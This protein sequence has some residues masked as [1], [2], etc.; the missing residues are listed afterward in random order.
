MKFHRLIALCSLLLIFPPIL[1]CSDGRSRALK[2]TVDALFHA[3]TIGETDI[4]FKLKQ[5]MLM[6]LDESQEYFLSTPNLEFT[7]PRSCRSITFVDK[8]W[9]F[10]LEY[11]TNKGTLIATNR[12]FPPNAPH[13]AYIYD[14]EFKN[15]TIEEIPGTLRIERL[16]DD[17]WLQTTKGRLGICFGV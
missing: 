8:D 14:A 2:P 15:G 11:D 1:A 5:R 10:V 16:D 12:F 3:V 4:S 9:C 13:R 7:I 17:H 6:G